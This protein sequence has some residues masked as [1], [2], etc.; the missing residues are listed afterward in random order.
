MCG[1][2]S[3]LNALRL[4]HNHACA[5]RNKKDNVGLKIYH[6]R[7]PGRKYIDIT[8]LWALQFRY[9]VNAKEWQQISKY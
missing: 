8:M 2:H 4:Q 6:M 1:A 5:F 9:S 3:D 7:Q